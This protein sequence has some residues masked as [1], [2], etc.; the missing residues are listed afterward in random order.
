MKLEQQ[1]IFFLQADPSADFYRQIEYALPV[2]KSSPNFESGRKSV[3]AVAKILADP[4]TALLADKARD[5]QFAAWTLVARYRAA[6]AWLDAAAQANE[7]IPA[8]ESALILETLSEMKWNDS[9]VSLQDAFRRLQLTEKDGWQQ[10]RPKANEDPDEIMSQAVA[11]WFRDHS[12]RYRLQRLVAK[13][14]NAK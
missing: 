13:T 5:R 8:D 11:K 4:Q 7:P 1:A 10:P 6:P 12:G 9:S 2:E 3:V 14:S